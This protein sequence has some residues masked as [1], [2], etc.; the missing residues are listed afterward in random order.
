LY[1]QHDGNDFELCY[2]DILEQKS[3]VLTNNDV[4]DFHPSFSQDGTVI[5]WCQVQK[6]RRRLMNKTEILVSSWPDFGEHHL[7]RDSMADCYPVFSSDSNYVIVES[8]RVDVKD[9][10][11]LF[12]LFKISMD[13][14]RS[15]LYYEPSLSGNG[16]P[17]M[18]GD[19][20]LFEGTVL[21]DPERRNGL[22]LDIF[23]TDL[24]HPGKRRRLTNWATRGN[25]SP[26][27]S[28]DGKKIACYRRYLEDGRGSR[29]VILDFDAGEARESIVIGS[30]GDEF[31]MPRWNRNGTL[32]VAEDSSRKG[33]IIADL[34][35]NAD[36]LPNLGGYRTQRFLEL[37][38]F[39]V[40]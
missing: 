12:G 13:G 4:D 23:V 7:T 15:P 1:S 17:H 19:T 21:L 29:I 8:G 18:F 24:A 39:D 28:P 5:A 20:A 31:R 32:I 10:S 6:M 25:P 33:L 9:M 40:H 30:T 35:G 16:I 27:F 34:N 22:A 3:R 38:N 36:Y 37:Y 26:R 2:Y 14:K 11:G